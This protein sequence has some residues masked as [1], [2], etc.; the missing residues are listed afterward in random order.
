[1][2]RIKNHYD[3]C[4]TLHLSNGVV[5]ESSKNST[6]PEYY[7][8]TPDAIL[9]DIH[10]FSSQV[11]IVKIKHMNM[12]CCPHVYPSDKFRTTNFLLDSIQPF[13]K[14]S[15]V[16]DMGCG[17]GIVGLYAISQGAKK[18]VQADINPF[19]IK[20]AEQN[21]KYHNIKDNAIDIHLSD[22]FDYIVLQKFDTIV[23][24]LPFHSD[25]IRIRDP[26]EHAFFDPCFRTLRKFLS[27][28]EAYSH[29]NTHIFLAFSNKGDIQ[30]LENIFEDSIF[31]WKLWKLSNQGEKHDNRI[32]LLR[33]N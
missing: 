15:R 29:N 33:N 12:V 7:M 20:N 6:K 25:F 23:F 17:P 10:Q 9:E 5:K 28:V 4:Q 21:K 24:N 3:P 18:V 16:C 26:L 2:T 19:A 13:L 11:R 8:L 32:Y 31:D 14:D 27:Q 30:T 1:M 22:C